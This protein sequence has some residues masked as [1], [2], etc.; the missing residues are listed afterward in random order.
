MR[1]MQESGGRTEPFVFRLFT[2]GGAG[3]GI[4]LRERQSTLE[5][6]SEDRLATWE[7]HRSDPDEPGAPIGR[8]EAT[9]EAARFEHVQAI[10]DSPTFR[11][12]D[13]AKQTGP[14]PRFGPLG[15]TVFE[16]T[17]ECRGAVVRKSI[18][19]SD[20]GLLDSLEPLFS[21]L[22][23]IEVELLKHPVAAVRAK[24][25]FVATPLGSDH[26]V[27]SI[28]N[29]GREPVYIGN[30]HR[31][32]ESKLQ[33]AGQPRLRWAGVRWAVLPPETP[34]VIEAPL[35]WSYLSLAMLAA[36]ESDPIDVRIEAG[37]S[38][39]AR[40]GP[41]HPPAGNTRFIVEGI[42]EN[43]EGSPR[44][45]G[46]YRIRGA[47]FSKAKEFGADKPEHIKR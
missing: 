10:A 3:R 27:L 39:V 5:L 23:G 7:R 36:S 1:T 9:L 19:N 8:F 30:P 44:V 15:T 34:G 46:V 28:E 12:L 22:N 4:D 42:L 35:E 26:F 37:K 40:T 21:E 11:E 16:F 14:L 47:V 2:A 24:V 6:R 13:R 31:L 20:L 32:D 38:Y 29:I 25:Q 41:F 45:G 18:A 33:S 17:Y 43:Y